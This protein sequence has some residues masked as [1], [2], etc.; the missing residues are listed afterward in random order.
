MSCQY[1]LQICQRLVVSGSIIDLSGTV[2]TVVIMTGVTA[3]AKVISVEEVV[4]AIASLIQQLVR[5][6]FDA[7][8]SLSSG[9]RLR[10][11]VAPSLA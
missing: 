2:V 3:A 8:W 11:M 6:V 10:F 9:L 7:S 5:L 1:V 4:E